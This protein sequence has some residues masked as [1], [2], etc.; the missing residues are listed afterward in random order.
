MS[1]PT[2]HLRISLTG[3][4]IVKRSSTDLTPDEGHVHVTLDGKLISMTYGL[5]QQIPDL[6][7]GPHRIEVEFVAMDHAPFDPRVTDVTSFQ[8]KG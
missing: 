7:P 6:S 1:G 3:A 5:E 4:R 8:V 2:V